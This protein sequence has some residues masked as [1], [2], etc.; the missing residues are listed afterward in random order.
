MEQRVGTCSLC[1]GDVVGVRGVWMCIHPPPPDRCTS[2]GAVSRTDVIDMV[3]GPY[4]PRNPHG[5]LV[6]TT[7]TS[8]H[9][10][11][12]PGLAGHHLFFH[13]RTRP[14]QRIGGVAVFIGC[15]D[16]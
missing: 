3:P 6:N 11:K 7:T 1:G 5:T 8:A 15:S 14:R 4:I 12:T 2:C 13:P 9:T 10:S 16:G